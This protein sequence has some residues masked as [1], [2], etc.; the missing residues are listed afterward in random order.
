MKNKNKKQEIFSYNFFKKNRKGNLLPEEVL[1]IIVALICII[2]LVFLLVSLYFSLTG[3]QKKKEAE[4]MMKDN[5]GLAK[6]IEKI[7]TKGNESIFHV[8][9]PSG[10][11]IF[12][13]VGTAKKPNLCIG[14]SCICIC[15]KI[16]MDVFDRQIKECNSNG[17]CTTVPNLNSFG[18]IKIENAGTWISIAKVNGNIEI[19]RK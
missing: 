18:N 19:K 14:A 3:D 17:V 10:W 2:F 1:K 15:K 12:S 5:A 11:F 7:N 13:F 16:W 4:S 8:K 6:E 9:N